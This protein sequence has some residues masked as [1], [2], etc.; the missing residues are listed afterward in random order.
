MERYI[1]I[2][3]CFNNV[4]G[5]I[6]QGRGGRFVPPLLTIRLSVKSNTDW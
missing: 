5:H 3:R 6:L 2:D 4:Q 1:G